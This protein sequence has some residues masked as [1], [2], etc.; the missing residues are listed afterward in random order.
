MWSLSNYKVLDAH[1]MWLTKETIL[2]RH[3]FALISVAVKQVLTLTICFELEIDAGSWF[4]RLT[5]NSVLSGLLYKERRILLNHLHNKSLGRQ[6]LIVKNNSPTMSLSRL[7][8]NEPTLM[9]F[10]YLPPL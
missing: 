6:V 1:Y 3:R 2:R 7:Y 9:T 4:N 5:T 8:A 10:I